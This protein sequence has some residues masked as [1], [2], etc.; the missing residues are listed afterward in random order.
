M[1]AIAEEVEQAPAD[2]DGSGM[3]TVRP[4]EHS[5]SFDQIQRV[6]SP[7]HTPD[8]GR[9]SARSSSNRRSSTFGQN[10]GAY[11]SENRGVRHVARPPACRRPAAACLLHAVVLTAFAG[12]GDPPR[13]DAPPLCG[14]RGLDGVATPPGNAVAQLGR[15]RQRQP[16]AGPAGLAG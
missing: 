14:R 8:G 12:A 2:Y 15:Q 16:A 9:S 10:K 3:V 7:P 13:V 11:G 4:A 6:E 1:A 5:V